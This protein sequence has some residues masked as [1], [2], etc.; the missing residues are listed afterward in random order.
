MPIW[1]PK[2]KKELIASHYYLHAFWNKTMKGKKIRNWPANKIIRYHRHIVALM[3]RR[4][5]NHK[6]PLELKVNWKKTKVLTMRFHYKKRPKW[7]R[8]INDCTK[9]EAL[10]KHDICVKQEMEG[11]S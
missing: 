10:L 11:K 1:N 3:I 5:W 4:G 2:N 9:C 6:S 7:Y 8:C